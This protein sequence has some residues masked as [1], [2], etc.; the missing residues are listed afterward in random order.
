MSAVK[1][2]HTNLSS[3]IRMHN[4]L[5]TK[6]AN[7][8]YSMSGSSATTKRRF[9]DSSMA[10]DDSSTPSNTKRTSDNQ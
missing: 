4:V 8:D 6:L 10:N 7:G 1:D 9:M 5:Q 2:T 3:E